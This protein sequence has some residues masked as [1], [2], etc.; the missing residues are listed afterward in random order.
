MKRW[1]L[2][3][4]V[5]AV[6]CWAAPALG[7]DVCSLTEADFA[8]GEVESAAWR[9]AHLTTSAPY[10]NFSCELAQAVQVTLT[11]RQESTGETVYARDYGTVSG[12]FRSEDVFLRQDGGTTTYRITLQCGETTYSFPLDLT[13]PRL[14]G[15]AACSAGYPLSALNGRDVWQTVTLL[16]VAALEGGSATYD[17]YASNRY[18][19]GSVRFS[20][21]GGA[22]SASVS[23][24]PQAEAQVDSARVYVASTA[25]EAATLGRSDCA[26]PSGG[27]D[28][29]IPCATGLAAVY[30][31]LTVSFQGEGLPEGLQKE[32]SGQAEL[33][34]R[35]CQETPAEAVG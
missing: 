17:L 6:L 12:T 2:C 34:Q 20:V 14:E 3:L 1:M 4:W 7:E 24:D 21:A 30:V 22:V 29:P 16:D 19:L 10:V 11:I 27:L 8:V 13:A 31:Q 15:N 28:S 32:W 23:L 5:A 26:A 9:E 33:W 35:M 18:V 25:L